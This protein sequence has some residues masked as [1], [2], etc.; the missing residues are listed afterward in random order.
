MALA[1]LRGPSHAVPPTSRR[2]SAGTS[3]ALVGRLPRGTSGCRYI[4]VADGESGVPLWCLIPRGHIQRPPG[5]TQG[6]VHPQPCEDPLQI[7]RRTPP[8]LRRTSTQTRAQTPD[9]AARA[10][11]PLWLVLGN[12]P[13]RDGPRGVS[14][15]P[16]AA[17]LTVGLAVAWRNGGHAVASACG[18]FKTLAVRGASEARGLCPGSERG[19]G[20]SLHVGYRLHRTLEKGYDPLCPRCA[21]VRG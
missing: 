19:G 5:Q 12:S 4:S 11:A 3:R 13:A 9:A 17:A 15:A 1:G 10:P 21:S 18:P 6:S 16:V 7:I 14:H 8:V 20:P 2:K